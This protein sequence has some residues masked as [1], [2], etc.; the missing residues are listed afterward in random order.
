MT[1]DLR[2]EREKAEGLG[3]LDVGGNEAGV[4]KAFHDATNDVTRLWLAV[5]LARA[6]EGAGLQA[7]FAGAGRKAREAALAEAYPD[8]GALARRLEALLPL[9]WE[10]GP[11][12]EAA[13]AKY[14]GEWLGGLARMLLGRWGEDGGGELAESAPAPATPS[15]RQPAGGSRKPPRKNSVITKSGGSGRKSGIGSG[16]S[17]GGY[18][19]GGRY[20]SSGARSGGSA[21]D[22]V[23]L[24][25]GDDDDIPVLTSPQ[26]KQSRK[27]AK[28][29]AAAPAMPADSSAEAPLPMAEPPQ[30]SAPEPEPVLLG[31]SAPERA[32]PG[33]TVL[34]QFAAYVAACEPKARQALERFA[35]D[36]DTVYTG[37]AT[38]CRWAVGT[39]IS[40]RCRADGLTIP[41][42][43]KG[44]VWNGQCCT[45]RFDAKVPADAAP[46]STVIVVEAFVHDTPD[47]PD[48][49]NV[50][51]LLMPL[52]IST[53]ARAREPARTVNGTPARTAFASYAS[54][55]RVD[56]LERVASIEVSAGLKV[57]M[58]VIDLR[59][60][61]QWNPKL[62][63]H[64]RA[65]DRFLLF[66]SEHAADSDWV[67]WERKKAVELHGERVLELHLLRFT[68]IEKVPEDLRKYHFNDI[69]LQAIDAQRYRDEQAAKAAAAAANAPKP[70]A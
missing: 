8:P 20:G 33:D 31:G 4:L 67:T 22:D 46:Q 54:Q 53:E 27:R 17:G 18:S 58:D 55:D 51:E 43:V 1:Q 10:L 52:E 19:G 48:P 35:R 25:G 50:A 47:A 40:V 6:G 11:M 66:W 23:D 30:A 42:P 24:F 9:P 62:D 39:R 68:P 34:V 56:V 16:T 60:G 45:V 32:R 65:S 15:R 3:E 12:L 63:E 21:S 26:R 70:G 28:P 41:T 5:A 36:E 64:I 13:A 38:S 61:D 44:F 49:F 59:M 69:H 29:A 7:L 57:W 37:E 14:A 2:S